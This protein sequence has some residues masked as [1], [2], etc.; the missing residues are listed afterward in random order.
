MTKEE[1]QT[2]H[3]LLGRFAVRKRL[4]HKQWKRTIDVQ[5]DVFW[6][7]DREIREREEK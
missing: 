2:L 1:L 7:W 4:T 3:E 5:R 6:V